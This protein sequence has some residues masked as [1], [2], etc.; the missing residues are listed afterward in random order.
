MQA[1]NEMGV[2]V[3][4]VQHCR[5]AGWEVARIGAAYPDATIRKLTT[6]ETREVEFEHTS[7]SFRAH[8]HDP[9]KCDLVI[10]W[11]HNDNDMTLP[12]WVLSAPQWWETEPPRA[13]DAER[14]IAYW[15]W[16]ALDAESQLRLSSSAPAVKQQAG[17][18]E[19]AAI[20]RAFSL[21]DIR[22]DMTTEEISAAVSRSA[23]SVQNYRRKWQAGRNGH[24]QEAQ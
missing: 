19:Q 14:E 1:E 15:R 12:L 6:G 23:R 10:C 21:W 7:A 9:R 20:E 5:E 8:K 16:R 11:E 4:F 13:T 2:I 3:E 17:L 18:S 24:A 22:P